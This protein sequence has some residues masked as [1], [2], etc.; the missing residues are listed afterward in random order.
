MQE[1]I[2]KLGRDRKLL[3]AQVVNFLVLLFLLKKFLYK[4]VLELLARRREGIARSVAN[5]ERI[6]QELQSIEDRKSVEIDKAKKEGDVIIEQARQAAKARGEELFKEA[7][8]RVE[9]LV[10]DAK[11]HIEE[12]RAAMMQEVAGEVKD[13]VFL[14][15]EKVLQERLPVS[16]NERF[17]E[18][19]I[20]AVRRA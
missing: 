12:D 9:K 7:E 16:V 5:A 18:E 20:S 6:S 11:Q 8:K 4:P 1:L 17:V 14:A 13:L 3:A 2:H 10:K 19:A 15:T